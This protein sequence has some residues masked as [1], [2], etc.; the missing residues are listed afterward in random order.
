MRH[1]VAGGWDFKRA[2]VLLSCSFLPSIFSVCSLCKRLHARFLQDKEG[3]RAHCLG[4]PGATTAAVLCRFAVW[5]LSAP[6]VRPCGIF[7]EVPAAPE[8]SYRYRPGK[9]SARTP[10]RT[11]GY[12]SDGRCSISPIRYTGQKDSIFL[13]ASGTGILP[14]L[15]LQTP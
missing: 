15:K 9:T 5:P 11:A 3:S 7:Q 12:E 6:S 4:C 1:R 13:G 2:G 10:A 8:I 14:K